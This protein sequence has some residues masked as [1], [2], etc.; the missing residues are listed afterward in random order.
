MDGDGAKKAL[1]DSSDARVF[2]TIVGKRK[3]FN[4]TL[5]RFWQAA[6]RDGLDDVS[7]ATLAKLTTTMT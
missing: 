1:P 2:K 4:Q 6:E 3:S 7:V 5:M